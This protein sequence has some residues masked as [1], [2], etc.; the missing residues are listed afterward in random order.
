MNGST[1]CKPAGKPPLGGPK[2]SN[3]NPPTPSTGCRPPGRPFFGEPNGFDSKM[4]LGGSD[5]RDLGK[6]GRAG[7][8]VAVGRNS[9]C[10]LWRVGVEA[11]VGARLGWRSA[12]DARLFGVFGAA[13]LAGSG[14]RD[15]SSLRDDNDELDRDVG[16]GT[17]DR[18][19]ELL[20]VGRDAEVLVEDRRKF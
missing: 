15:L 4:A 16:V 12:S 11:W 5:C 17:F 19:L 2:E 13:E 7:A 1:G 6:A 10:D 18:R 3:E 14:N 9:A 20:P 8:A